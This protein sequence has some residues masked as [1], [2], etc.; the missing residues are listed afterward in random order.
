MKKKTR[1]KAIEQRPAIGNVFAPGVVKLTCGCSAERRRLCKQRGF[2]MQEPHGEAPAVKVP[3]EH[4]HIFVTEN[5]LIALAHTVTQS[6]FAQTQA[7]EAERVYGA[8]PE[9]PDRGD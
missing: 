3:N 4:C 9:E 8:E 6:R 1:T 5:D 7:V 2:Y